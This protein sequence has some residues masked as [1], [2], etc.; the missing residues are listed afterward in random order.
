MSTAEERRA[1]STRLVVLQAATG[2][3]FA[4]LAFG[5]WYLQVVQHAKF[6]E[7]AE[8]NQIGRAHV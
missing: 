3:L 7:M 2:A 1:I 4:V 5:F 8:N 6:Q